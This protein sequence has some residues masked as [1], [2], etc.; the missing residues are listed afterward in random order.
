MAR[1][2]QM[3]VIGVEVGRAEVRCLVDE[4]VYSP[5]GAVHGGL[6]ATLLDTVTGLAVQ[7]TLPEGMSFT[8][9]QLTVNFLRPVHGS[10]GPLTAVGT[11][12]KPG[13]R[14]A[15]AEGQVR[16]ATGRVVA[17]ATSSLLVFPLPSVDGAP[18]AR[19]EPTATEDIR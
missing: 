8:S 16:N 7:A 18:P 14:V 12:V 9:I 4:S 2:L 13:R 3:E 1:L 10:S 19:P 11:I 6:V 15:F 5:L 17:T